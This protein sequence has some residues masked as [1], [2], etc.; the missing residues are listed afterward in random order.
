M[1][2]A[3]VV[4]AAAAV[5]QGSVNT[6]PTFEVASVKRLAEPS[7]VTGGCHGAPMPVFGASNAPAIPVGRCVISAARLSHLIPIAYDIPLARVKG[8]PEWV[9]GAPRFNIVAKAENPSATY[10]EL[11]QMLQTL[12]ADRFKLRV[13]REARPL[14][15]FAL[16][17]GRNGPRF[18]ASTSTQAPSLVVRG[19]AINKLDAIDSKNLDLNTVTG[20][21][22]SMAQLAEALSRLPGDVPFVD[23]TG[24][25]GVYDI[26]LSWEPDEDLARVVQDQLGLRLERGDVPA[27]FIIVDSAELPTEN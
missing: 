17:I 6:P 18:K 20:R 23:R 2:Y 25:T 10:A 24:L 4:L 1:R 26:S 27:G 14:S 12:L 22:I 7:G 15:G 8:G 5:F 3:W 11:T 9:W 16:L 21:K 13:H 19:A